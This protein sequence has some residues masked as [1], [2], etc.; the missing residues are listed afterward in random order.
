MDRAR[1]G[2]DVFRKKPEEADGNAWNAEYEVV[3]YYRE[4][5]YEL[6]A[7]RK[8]EPYKAAYQVR[9]QK[10]EEAVETAVRIF[11]EQEQGSHVAWQRV[12]ERIE[13]SG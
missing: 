3:I 4:P 5:V 13:I 10:K 12:I 2:H 1:G 11:R 9:A 7:G 6:R 8:A